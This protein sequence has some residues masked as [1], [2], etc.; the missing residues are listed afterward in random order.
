MEYL[1]KPNISIPKNTLQTLQEPLKITEIIGGIVPMH[2]DEIDLTV[3]AKI[4]E[5][6]EPLKF[7][8]S[9]GDGG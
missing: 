6:F 8:I 1:S 9:I 2:S 5:F 3:T 7:P 4:E